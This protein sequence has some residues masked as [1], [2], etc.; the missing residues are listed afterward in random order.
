MLDRE[1]MGIQVQRTVFTIIEMRKEPGEMIFTVR[2]G[3]ANSESTSE[4]LNFRSI[5]PRKAK[6]FLGI[7]I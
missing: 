1:N 2:T 6:A 3:N 4:N 5:N 7:L